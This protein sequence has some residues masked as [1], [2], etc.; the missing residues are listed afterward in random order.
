MRANGLSVFL[1]RGLLWVCALFAIAMLFFVNND[2]PPPRRKPSARPSV[3]N[4]CSGDP[5]SGSA[6][7]AYFGFVLL[8]FKLL[9]F[10]QRFDGFVL[11]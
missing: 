4:G 7:G 5:S 10:G 1:L 11:A 6:N 2:T 8:D 3:N 9:D